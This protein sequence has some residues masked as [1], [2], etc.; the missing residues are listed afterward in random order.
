M[1]EWEAEKNRWKAIKADAQLDFTDYKV[2]I[3][4]ELLVWFWKEI[5]MVAGGAELLNT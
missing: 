3:H 2:V 1:G 5:D 4:I